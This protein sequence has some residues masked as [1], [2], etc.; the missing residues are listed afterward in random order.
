MGVIV[1]NLKKE[2]LSNTHIIFFWYIILPRIFFNNY[3][4][5]LDIFIVNHFIIKSL[6]VIEFSLKDYFT[7]KLF[8]C[9]K[10]SFCPLK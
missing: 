4:L 6:K 2:I 7:L 10:K 9:V 8:K 1:I 3:I 5:S